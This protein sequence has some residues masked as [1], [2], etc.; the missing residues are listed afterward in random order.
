VTSAAEPLLSVVVVTPHGYK[1]IERTM[2]HLRAQTIHDRLE[3]LIAAPSSA[4]L[5]MPPSE[6]QGLMRL[7]VVE[8]GPIESSAHA[9]AVAV[10][11]ASAAIVALAE[12]H[13]F[14]RPG[15]AEAL[16][17]AHRQPWAAV[18][19]VLENANPSTLTSWAN[20]LVE[21]APFL[22][23]AQ[24]AEAE[25]LP[26]HNGSYK[27][28]VLLQYG[29]QLGAMLEAESVLHWD[30][31]ARGHRL[32]LEPAARVQHLNFSRPLSWLGLRFHGGRA[33][34]AARSRNWP[35][36][37]RVAYACG[38]P[39]IPW[40]RLRRIVRELQ[41]PGRPSD[42]LPT[43]LPLVTLALIVDAAGEMAGY[44]LGAGNSQRKLAGYEFDRPRYLTAEDRRALAKPDGGLP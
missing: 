39:L 24:P 19:P 33:F 7:E 44:T 43:V 22:H 5:A 40:V 32:Y 16:V 12:D 13:S 9:R 1:T 25:H 14:P 30:L 21:Y 15:W 38:G 28:D 42:L 41:R 18:G 2:A 20:L 26:G 34:A 35:L 29:P 37:R 3:V 36:W 8:V 4:E 23:P 31:G 6:R 17:S 10:R 11:Q 27:R